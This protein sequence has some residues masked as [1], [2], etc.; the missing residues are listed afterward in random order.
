MCALQ[1]VFSCVCSLVYA[2]AR[3]ICVYVYEF[4]F[5]IVCFVCLRVS[6]LS[7]CVC[8]FAH[9]DNKKSLRAN[10]RSVN[11]H[12]VCFPLSLCVCRN[13][14]VCCMYVCG[15]FRPLSVD[16]HSSHLILK[17]RV[18]FLIAIGFAFNLHYPMIN[19]IKCL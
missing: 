13:S 14:Y 16:A 10:L 15:Q 8:T 3:M 6:V 1:C 19:K 4:V 17:W 12:F 2:F 7:V 11:P 18:A 9:V 5:L